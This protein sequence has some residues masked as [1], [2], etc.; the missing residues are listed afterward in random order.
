MTRI[1]RLTQAIA[2]LEELR[3]AH[4][5]RKRCGVIQIVHG[6]PG[7]PV[8]LVT[9]R[10]RQAELARLQEELRFARVEELDQE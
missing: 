8:G 4:D 5:Q 2:Q 1:E 6:V 3:D 10:F 9:E 7:E